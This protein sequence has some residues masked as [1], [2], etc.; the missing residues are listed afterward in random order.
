MIVVP[1]DDGTVGIV[2]QST[3]RQFVITP[4][5]YQELQYSQLSGICNEEE[6]EEEG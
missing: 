6:E 4:N 5:E 2:F 1:L 3:G